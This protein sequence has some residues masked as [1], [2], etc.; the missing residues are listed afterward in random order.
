MVWKIITI[1]L[2][3]DALVYL[4]MWFETIY[5]RHDLPRVYHKVLEAFTEEDE[6]EGEAIQ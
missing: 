4:F 2:A 3:F 6:D 5:Y 1:W